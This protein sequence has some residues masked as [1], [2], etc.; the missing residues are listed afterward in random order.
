M[1]ADF[2]N[3]ELSEENFL[4]SSLA[5]LFE[6]LDG[7]EAQSEIQ[8]LAER[9]K[10][11]LKTRFSIDMCIFGCFDFVDSSCSPVLVTPNEVRHRKLDV[12]V[13]L[14]CIGTYRSQPQLGPKMNAT[15]TNLI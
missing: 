13:Y 5:S 14:K 15:L 11:L 6:I 9:L 3:D 7:I 12:A 1:S 4:M 8:K 10:K 2:F